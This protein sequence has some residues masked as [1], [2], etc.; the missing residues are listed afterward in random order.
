MDGS[1]YPRG[2]AGAA[3]PRAARLLA[4]ADAYQTLAEDRPGPARAHATRQRSARCAPRSRAGRLDAGVRARPCSP[5]PGTGCAAA[6][7]LVAGLTAREVE[8]LALLVRGLSNKQI[9]ERLSITPRTVGH[10]IEH[11]FAK[12][13][14]STRGA[15]AM[16][17]LRHG[18]VDA[19]ERNIGRSP[20]VTA[21]PAAL[22]H[23]T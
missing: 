11:I 14:V 4:A 2:L 21:P 16:F 3:M 23:G 10:H 1:G 15:A 18:L 6:R 9:A 8:V 13:G 7:T 22:E 12:T 17:A 20:D 5:P 19:G